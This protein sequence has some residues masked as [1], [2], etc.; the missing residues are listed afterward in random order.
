VRYN[1][2][3]EAN[4]QIVDSD[5]LHNEQ[6]YVVKR[7]EEHFIGNAKE[8]NG[9]LREIH[10]SVSPIVVTYFIVKLLFELRVLSK[11][12]LCRHGADLLL[13]LLNFCNFFLQS[14]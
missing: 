1:I 5:E 10:C 9:S 13:H 6:H 11:V 3:N 14:F 12:L 2:N 4:F 7:G 8:N